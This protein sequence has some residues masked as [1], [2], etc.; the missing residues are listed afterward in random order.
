MTIHVELFGWPR[1]RAG[2]AAIDVQGA[3]LGEI[4]AALGRA[5]PSLAD[6][7]LDGDRLRPGFLANLNGQTFVTDPATPLRDGDAVLILSSDVGG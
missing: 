2:V 3:R 6:A 1:H 4:L 7:C 5:L